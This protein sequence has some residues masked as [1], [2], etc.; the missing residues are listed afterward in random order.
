ME[1]KNYRFETLQV[2]AGQEIDPVSKGTAVPI[3]VQ[4]KH[5]IPECVKGDAMLNL[6]KDFKAKAYLKEEGK[7]LV[8]QKEVV[9]K[10]LKIK[11]PE[12]VLPQQMPT[13]IKAFN[14]RIDKQFTKHAKRVRKVLAQF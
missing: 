5:N 10:V 7:G 12:I 11:L 8:L 4:A 3:Y 9:R 14:A 13:D 2:R 6:S 1:K